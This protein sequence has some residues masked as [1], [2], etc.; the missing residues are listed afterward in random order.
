MS[1][2]HLRQLSAGVLL[3]SLISANSAFAS[4]FRIPEASIAGLAASNALVADTESP[5]A[6]PYNPAAMAFHDGRVLIV[7]LINVRPTFEA[8][9]DIGS[10]TNSKGASSVILPSGYFMDSIDTN[11][12]W[13]ISINTPFGLETHWP[14]GTFTAVPA[15][16]EPE[17]SK[18]ELINVN[19]NIAYLINESTSLAFGID[20]HV[21]RKLIFN[22]QALKIEG[23]GADFGWNIG[24]QHKHKNWSF[25]LSYRSGVSID[26]DGSIYA[27][28][29]PAATKGDAS[30]T[31]DLPDLL[32]IGARYQFNPAWA[33]EFD[34][35]QTGWSTFD[36]VVINHT[37]PA[38]PTPI[39]SL[40]N[41]D[42][43]IAYRLSGAY[44]ANPST[45]YRFGYARDGSPQGET[46]FSPRIPDGERQTLSAG[47]SHDMGSY[48]IEA[49]YMIAWLERTITASAAY[50]GKY[51]SKAHLLGIGLSSQF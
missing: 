39:T 7:S 34:I 9:P 2:T 37:S 19:P 48:S 5:G 32:Q 6:L 41:W 38:A 35:E 31:L 47:F 36:V 21:V 50:S 1:Q 23:D 20:Y 26:L 4:G 22:T 29:V 3:A 17:Q 46:D 33:V 51:E 28:A 24:L 44:Q 45:Q 11:T 12:S 10:S 8:D 18:L 49:G 42:D 30:T 15:S 25:G 13:G 43:S 14:S 40:N 27:V 16:F